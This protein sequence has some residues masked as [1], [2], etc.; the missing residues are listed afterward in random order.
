M[1]LDADEHAALDVVAE[2]LQRDRRLP[3]F[4]VV[5][6]GSE[7]TAIA[8]LRAGVK[9]YFREPLDLAMLTASARRWVKSLEGR[10]PGAAVAQPP[11]QRELPLIAAS[12]PMRRIANY[13]ARVAE[14]DATVLITG[15][16]G[17]GKEL[18]AALIH[19][20]SPRRRGRFVSVNC[21]AIPEGLLETELFG[22]EPGAFTGAVGRRDGLMQLA[23]GGTILLDEIGDLAPIG[24]A[25]LL[26][27]IETRE[28]YRVGGKRP[29]PLDVRF[30]AATNHDL[31]RAADEGRFRKDLYYRLA[32]VRV[33]LPALRERRSD[34]GALLDHYLQA[35]RPR[36]AEA[37]AALAVETREVLEAYDWPGNVRELKNLVEALCIVPP[38]RPVLVSDLPETFRERLRRLAASGGAERRQLLDALLAANWNK[39]RAA[40]ML[41]WSRMTVYRK[42]AKYSVSRSTDSRVRRRG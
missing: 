14:H 23:D 5:D 13:L 17:T 41:R 15:E 21:A 36:G 42:M 35:F 39:S 3:V 30:V 26:R 9:D 32:V 10:R 27:A 12:A 2:L 24:Q 40:K 25:K 11:S 8:A 37:P 34:I 29:E 6:R 20:S 38:P 1:G 19:E 7:T 16:T 33:H 4:F 31:E 28:V 18:A 22:Y